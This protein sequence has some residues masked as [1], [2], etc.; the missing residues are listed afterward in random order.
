[1]RSRKPHAMR[2]SKKGEAV[3]VMT[4]EKLSFAHNRSVTAVENT[5]RRAIE[6]ISVR[7][8]RSEIENDIIKYAK[9]E[10]KFNGN[11]NAINIFI[12]GM[13]VGY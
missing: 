3:V 7:N 13:K 6:W 4:T 11:L 5:Q 9:F 10:G 12:K 8:I 2:G 1:M